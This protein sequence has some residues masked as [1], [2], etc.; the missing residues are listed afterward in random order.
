MVIERLPQRHLTQHHFTGIFAATLS[1]ARR[2][3]IV[4]DL[5]SVPT[6]VPQQGPRTRAD[7]HTI[8]IAM[9]MVDVKMKSKIMKNAGVRV[10]M[11]DAV[12]IKAGAPEARNHGLSTMSE[13]AR[14]AMSLPDCPRSCTVTQNKFVGPLADL[15]PYKGKCWTYIYEVVPNTPQ[16]RAAAVQ[17]ATPPARGPEAQSKNRQCSSLVQD[18]C[19]GGAAGSAG[20]AHIHGGRDR[21]AAESTQ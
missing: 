17:N 11:G 18:L 21:P 3:N 14:G 15:N 1:M 9:E 2:Q 12:A 7:L 19:Q 20:H 6:A 8:D 10:T 5:A 13:R 16:A 4:V